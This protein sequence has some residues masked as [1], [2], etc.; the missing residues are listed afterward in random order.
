[1]AHNGDEYEIRI[2]YE[3][4]TVELS[5]W[6]NSTEQVAHAM[7]SVH[8]SQG[9]AYWLVVRR[10]DQIILECPITDIPPTRYI[11]HDSHYL[12]RVRSRDRYASGF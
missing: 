10:E 11:P 5:G 3:D 9:K 4:G 8:S 7:A 6:M 2:T 1:M 12:V